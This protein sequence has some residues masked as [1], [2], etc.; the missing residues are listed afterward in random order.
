MLNI[1]VWEKHDLPYRFFFEVKKKRMYVKQ[2]RKS[3]IIIVVSPFPILT[4]LFG[5]QI[6]NNSEICHESLKE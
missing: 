3:V 5:F 6:P 4:Q 1:T 2:P